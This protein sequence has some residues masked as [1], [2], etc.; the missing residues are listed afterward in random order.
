MSKSAVDLLA[1]VRAYAAKCRSDA[2]GE[3]ND[4]CH[5]V[6][7]AEAERADAAATNASELITAIEKFRIALAAVVLCESKKAVSKYTRDAI[8]SHYHAAFDR[9]T[10][11][12][13]GVKGVA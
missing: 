7:L 3:I 11:A 12:L 5:A 13:A 10:V 1:V 9:L 8:A 2:E 6:L 4:E